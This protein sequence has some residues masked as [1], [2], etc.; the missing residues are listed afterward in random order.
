M[1]R[2]MISALAMLAL[3]AIG[4]GD[5]DGGGSG[6]TSG[7]SGTG[8]TAGTA[9][10]SGTGGGDPGIC[11]GDTT[12]HPN[13]VNEECPDITPTTGPRAMKG[14]CCFRA[15]NADR[16]Q[17]AWD[18]DELATIEFRVNALQTS[19]QPNSVGNPLIQASLA[20]T[21]ETDWSNTLV[22]IEGIPKEGSGPVTVTIGAGRSNCDG[23]YSF[24]SDTSAP[25]FGAGSAPW[26]VERT[27]PARWEASVMAGTWDWDSEEKLTIPTANRPEGVR[28]APVAKDNGLLGYEQPSQDLNYEFTF[29]GTDSTDIT[30]EALNCA[31]G[32][33]LAES[34]WDASLVQTTFFPIADLETAQVDSLTLTQNFCSFL[35]VGFMQP[36]LCDEVPRVAPDGCEPTD[37]TGACKH[38]VELPVG[39][40]DAEH[41]Y[42]GDEDHPRA[43]CGGDTGNECCDPGADDDTMPDCNAFLIEAEAVLAGSEIT[44]EPHTDSTEVFPDCTAN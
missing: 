34:M 21:Y 36:E 11:T 12:D 5:D 15:S 43:N 31:G 16:A 20:T 9:G 3:L 28:W 30:A 13:C 37:N 40:C 10:D 26:F 44:D 33:L 6:G 14:A 1:R 41:C 22:R 18:N 24:F 32:R 17:A 42:V 27:D 39:F 19:S 7:A 8:G 25:D 23:T 4:C 38:W 35:A 2:T 29:D